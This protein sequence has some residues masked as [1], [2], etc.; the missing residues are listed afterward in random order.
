MTVVQKLTV[1]ISEI[2][3]AMNELSG[4]EKLE[5]GD[6]AKIE[7]LRKELN[8]KEV[9]F[10]AAVESEGDEET[11][12]LGLFNQVDAESAEKAK[13]LKEVRI[14]DYL[15]FAASSVGLSGR[16][17][18]LNAAL[19]VGPSKSG[20]ISIPWAVLAGPDESRR[21]QDNGNGETRAFTTTTQLAG[22][23]SQRPVLSRLFGVGI[24]MNLGVRMDAVPAGRA[25]W[26]LLT[27]G[28]VPAQVEEGTAAAAAVAPT[29]TTEILKP[30][31]LTGVYEYT[32]EQA[33]QVMGIEEALRRDLADAILAQMSNQILN[34]NETT[35]PEQVDGFLT[36]ISAPSD[37]P[38]E[39]A[40]ADYAG[41]ASQAVDGVHA[42][43]EGEVNC[44]IGVDSYRHAAAIY[45]TSGSGESASE[46]LGRRSGL[47]MASSFVPEK[48]ADKIQNGNILHAAGPGGGADRGDSVAG[49]WPSLDVIR[50]P[51]SKASTG[52]VLT[53]ITLWDAQTA[54]RTG[55][56][57]RVGF[58]VA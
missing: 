7:E 31:K 16:A 53:W 54:F 2:R 14:S 30:K 6:A 38:A 25:E 5:D 10:R 12:A 32:H 4:K 55:A 19:E 45:Q 27:A 42:S 49:I 57:K 46:A 47:L 43:S 20:G 50:D 26:P 23:V 1:K 40:F 37:P 41:S 36:T 52:V 18:E 48:K 28:V 22:G 44:V 34:G 35:N 8:D 51:Y 11:R 17:L 9:Q 24:L 3:Q 21:R 15:G 13:L 56:Y 33:A 29:F 39:S 58:K